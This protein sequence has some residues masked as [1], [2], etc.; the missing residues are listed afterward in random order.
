MISRLPFP[1]DINWFILVPMLA[2]SLLAEELTF[3][4]LIQGRLTPF[5]GKTYAILLASLLF[6]I[7]HFSPG[8]FLIVFLDV[9]SIFIDSILYG[10]IYARSHNLI[11]TWCAH[12]LGDIL[13]ML[14]LI[15]WTQGNLL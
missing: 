13:G 8:A 1:Q 14:F 12:L 2:F 11:V 5:I 6:G 10:I 4:S 9:A 15:L 7:A 3:R